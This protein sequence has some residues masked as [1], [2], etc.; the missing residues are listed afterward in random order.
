MMRLGCRRT[1]AVAALALA[2]A[3]AFTS[4]GRAVGASRVVSVKEFGAEGDGSTDDTA[5]IQSAWT[6]RPRVER[7]GSGPRPIGSAQTWACV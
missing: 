7:C 6:R 1:L 5:A 2:A 4:G 3:T